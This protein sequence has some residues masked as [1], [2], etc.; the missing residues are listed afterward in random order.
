MTHRGGS[1]S[2]TPETPSAL[3]AIPPT[4][5]PVAPPASVLQIT[6]AKGAVEASVTPSAGIQLSVSSEPSG[7]ILLKNGFQVCD[8]TPCEVLATP[9]ETLEFQAIKGARKGTA[10]VLAER[11]QKVL[12]K[13]LAAPV[14]TPAAAPRRP[15]PERM[16]EVEL[17][18]LKILR[19]CK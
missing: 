5:P 15:A 10:K 9:A 6:S 13:L 7:A 17:D 3:A 12:I 11:N 8:A 18:G 14:A 4:P 19:A 16:C 2:P 1:T